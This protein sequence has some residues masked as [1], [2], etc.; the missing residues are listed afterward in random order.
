MKGMDKVMSFRFLSESTE[1]ILVKFGMRE[2]GW[3]VKIA[4]RI[5]FR[6]VSS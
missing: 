6:F 1:R 5:L 2:I 3:T 4:E